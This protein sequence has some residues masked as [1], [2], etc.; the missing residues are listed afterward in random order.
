M[1]VQEMQQRKRELGLTNQEIADRCGLSVPTV[2]RIISG[3]DINSRAYS[4]E[5]IEAVLMDTPK[6]REGEAAYKYG[7]M[8]KKQGEY[9]L[10]DYFELPEDERCEIINGVIYDMTAP[11]VSHQ[12][13]SGAIY[14]IFWTHIKNN[15]GPCKTFSSP[16]DVILDDKTIVQPDVLILCDKNKIEKGRIKGA[17][18][19][20]V[21]VVSPSSRSRDHVLKLNKYMECGVRE[22]WIVDPLSEKITVYLFGEEWGGESDLEI[23]EY[24]FDD[25]VPVSIWSKECLV[26]F[27]EIKENLWE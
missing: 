24:S 12:D 19:F 17:P 13:I 10:E 27:A 16:I 18:D 11:V 26:D 7:Y 3:S 2:Q 20:V 6:L 8:K 14:G 9:T 5:M 23:Y 21:E 15:K 25:K 4:K 22:Y 1:T